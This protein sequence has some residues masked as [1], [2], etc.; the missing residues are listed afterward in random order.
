MRSLTDE[1][2][3]LFLFG[4]DE[5]GRDLFRCGRLIVMVCSVCDAW[6]FEEFNAYGDIVNYGWIRKVEPVPVI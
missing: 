5:M 3:R 1:E 6:S 2:M 4:T